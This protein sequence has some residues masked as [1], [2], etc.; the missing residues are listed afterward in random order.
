MQKYIFFNNF[1]I[2]KALCVY[3]VASSTYG[4]AQ[5]FLLLSP[6]V[7]R[8]VGIPKTK[9]EFTNPYEHLWTT[10]Q[11]RT[12][13]IEAKSAEVQTGTDQIKALSTENI[14]NKESNS[15]NLK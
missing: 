6:E 9:T 14:K 10:I 1:N 8:A 2:F 3:W 15:K 13:Q 12:G 7:R 11:I 4:L 5:N